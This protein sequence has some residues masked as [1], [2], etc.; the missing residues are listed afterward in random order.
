[1][2]PEAIKAIE[3]NIFTPGNYFYNG[4]GH[5]TVKYWEVLETGFEGIMEKAQ[6]EL[7][8]CSVGDGNYARK[9]HFLEAVILSCKAVIDYAGRYAKLAQ[10]MAAQT[11]DPVRK[12]EL[13][14]YR[15]ELQQGTGKGCTEFL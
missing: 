9:S 14:C 3:H 11:S 5:V 6:K 7:D 4:V 2:A 1:M 10:E 15:R 12:Q 13:F 8:G